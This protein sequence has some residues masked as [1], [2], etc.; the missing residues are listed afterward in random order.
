[1]HA[2]SDEAS[3]GER[4][5]KYLPELARRDRENVLANQII[6]KDIDIE[7]E[8]DD[9]FEVVNDASIRLGPHRSG[10][11]DVLTAP[12]RIR[13]LKPEQGLLEVSIGERSGLAVLEGIPEPPP[14]T[15]I[16]PPD[17]LRF[18]KDTYTLGLNKT[19]ALVIWAPVE[20]AEE[21]IVKG[22]RVR[23]DS[24]GVTVLDGGIATMSLD[25][26]LGFYT[27]A[28]R[29]TG[30]QLGSTSTLYATLGEHTTRTTVTIM[31]RDSGIAGLNIKFAS[32]DVGNLRSYFDPPG[33][34]SDEEQTL[35]IA[36]K[37]PSLLPLVGEDLS[38]DGTSEARTA[39]A[40]IVA[41]ALVAQIVTEKHGDQRVEASVLYES[42]RERLTRLLPKV[43]KVLD[44][45]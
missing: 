25:G 1:M 19:K 31:S 18:E 15:P 43:Q 26:E 27:S 12:V 23:S 39:L 30:S 9:A 44:V 5:Y 22:I 4:F 42:H 36:Q 28:I 17:R 34:R 20:L 32:H 14:P 10:R 3:R 38:R 35:W 24:E 41:E 16:E 33:R 7:R 40:E 45:V 8:P 29:V 13:A 2:V 37:H 6:T 21:M 11:T